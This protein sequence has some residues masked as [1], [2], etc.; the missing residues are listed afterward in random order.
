VDDEDRGLPRRRG[1]RASRVSHARDVAVRVASGR[2][3][4]RRGRSGARA[5]DARG[6]AEHGSGEGEDG[7]RQDVRMATP[8]TTPA[9]CHARG[10]TVRV[11]S[12][13]P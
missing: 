10:R 5:R 7:E 1:S 12:A 6:G 8:G 2:H 9:S 11:R 3:G 4:T 13:A